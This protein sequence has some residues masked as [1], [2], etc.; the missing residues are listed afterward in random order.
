[1]HL[2]TEEKPTGLTNKV[3]QI[4]EKGYHFLFR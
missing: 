1:M 3:S 2:D 4:S